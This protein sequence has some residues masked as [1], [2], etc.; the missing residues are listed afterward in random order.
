MIVLRALTP[1]AGVDPFSIV[2]FNYGR[3]PVAA[4][5]Y[6]P[7]SGLSSYLR[8][9]GCA[10]SHGR[11]ADR[12]RHRERLPG[13]E[14]FDQATSNPLPNTAF[15][16]TTP[17]RSTARRS[18][19]SPR[20]A[21]RLHGE[22][23][24]LPVVAGSTKKLTAVA[25]FDGNRKL[26]ASSSAGASSASTRSDWKA[27]GKAAKGKHVLRT[28]AATRPGGR[29]RQLSQSAFAAKPDPPF[30]AGAGCP[31]L[32]GAPRPVGPVLLRGRPTGR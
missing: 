21:G 29:R 22:D 10:G 27:A 9:P 6:D 26:G 18:R 12:D 1:A 17:A 19:G 2:F 15:K 7:F 8:R 13:D 11:E 14:E 5:V 31:G 28:L 30:C 32:P 23:D 25:F 4:A 24:L 3:V 16:Q 20:R